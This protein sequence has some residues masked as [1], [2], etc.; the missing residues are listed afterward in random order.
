MVVIGASRHPY[1]AR[2]GAPEFTPID[3]EGACT[4]IPRC[5]A[6]SSDSFRVVTGHDHGEINLFDPRM[7]KHDKTFPGAGPRCERIS[8]VSY[9][10]DSQ[11]FLAGDEA[12]N[13]FLFL[14]TR[15][16]MPVKKKTVVI[17]WKSRIMGAATSRYVVF[18]SGAGVLLKNNESQAVKRLVKAV[19]DDS[20]CFDARE[21]SSGTMRVVVWRARQVWIFSVKGS[22]VITQVFQWKFKSRVRE[23]ILGQTLVTTVILRQGDICLIVGTRRSR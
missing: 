7:G 3:T 13:I 17:S 16:I 12:G 2:A 20:A 14:R 5:V 19:T 6:L 23:C 11:A 18:A 4:Q 15:S 1:V 8:T 21:T 22:D 9:S 10:G